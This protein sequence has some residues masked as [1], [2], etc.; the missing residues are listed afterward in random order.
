MEPQSPVYELVMTE[1]RIAVI[2]PVYNSGPIVKETIESVL[3]QDHE[4][5]HLYIV[6]DG[7]TDD[8]T[9]YLAK[10]EKYKNATIIRQR[11][12]GQAAAINAAIRLSDEPF[13]SLIDADDL[14]TDRR[15]TRC[16]EAM[17]EHPKSSFVCSDFCRD[18]DPSKQW[19][20]AWRHDGYSKPS[21]TSFEVLLRENFVCRSTVL[22]RRQ[23]VVRA[24]GFSEAIGGRCGADDLHMW[25]S[26][27]H[28]NGPCHRINEV[29]VWK[30][31]SSSQE[32]KSL[33][34]LESCVR[35]WTHWESH[36]GHAV[37]FQKIV[38]CN[39][40]SALTDLVWR[41]R[42]EKMY[43][44]S[45]R[46]ALNLFSCPDARV[47]AACELAKVTVAYVSDRVHMAT[48]RR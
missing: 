33:H 19:H 7:S 21:K 14:W 17:C 26:L 43:N 11:N 31:E 41:Y 6:D 16:F 3:A 32:S 10:F 39:R 37:E 1:R 34:F 48:K 23:D 45:F 29:L 2:L 8:T 44:E 4:Q 28:G 36:L 12:T 46:G 27:C 30:R 25:M 9:Q 47:T 18:S 22:L 42:K 15:L 24:G 40:I 35:L 5:F 38:R 20:S 13:I